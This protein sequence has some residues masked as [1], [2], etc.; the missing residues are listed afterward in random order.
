MCFKNLRFIRKNYWIGVKVL[1]KFIKLK[2]EGFRERLRLIID[3]F[4][5]SSEFLDS[6]LSFVF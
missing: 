4:F 2:K 5:W 3:G 1:V 6:V